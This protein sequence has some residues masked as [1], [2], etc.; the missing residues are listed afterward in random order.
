MSLRNAARLPQAPVP[1]PILD[2][3]AAPLEQHRLDPGSLQGAADS[4]ADPPRRM[5]RAFRTVPAHRQ[6]RGG[7]TAWT[8]A[9]CRTTAYCSPMLQGGPSTTVSSRPSATTAARP[10]CTLGTCWSEGEEGTCGVA[11]VY[12]PTGLR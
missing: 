5:S 2:P 1:T 11:A 9:R 12:S 4:L 8:G 6:R 3:G 7:A 10:G